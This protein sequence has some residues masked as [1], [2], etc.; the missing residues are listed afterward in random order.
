[1][2]ISK[3]PE[4]TTIH[5]ADFATGIIAGLAF[6]GYRSIAVKELDVHIVYAYRDWVEEAEQNF[7]LRFWLTTHEIH[8]DAPEVRR[9]IRDAVYI[10]DLG[11][12]TDVALGFNISQDF[13]YRYFE[14]LPGGEELWVS[15]AKKIVQYHPYVSRSVMS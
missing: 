9:A 11:F 3:L 7:K 5:L 1:L 15:L 4:R 13:A 8:N 14:T 10:S 2:S 6:L 12:F